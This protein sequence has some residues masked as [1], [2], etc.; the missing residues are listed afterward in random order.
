MNATPTTAMAR[1]FSSI[2]TNEMGTII[3]LS[4][5]KTILNRNLLVLPVSMI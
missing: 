5:H 1:H 4:S 2:E 3:C